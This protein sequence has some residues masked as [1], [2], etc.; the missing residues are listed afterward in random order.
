LL[1]GCA[2]NAFL[3][4]VEGAAIDRRGKKRRPVQHGP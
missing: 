2:I 3:L 4:Y 1:V